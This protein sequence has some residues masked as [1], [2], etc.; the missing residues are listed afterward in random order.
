MNDL[1]RGMSLPRRELLIREMSSAQK[2]QLNFAL[3][4]PLVDAVVN[5]LRGRLLITAA[6]L[7]RGDPPEEGTRFEAMEIGRE[8]PLVE[9]KLPLNLRTGV[10]LPDVNLF[11]AGLT[12]LNVL[13]LVNTG[14][15]PWYYH[16]GQKGEPLVDIY[17]PRPISARSYHNL[18]QE[19]DLDTDETSTWVFPPWKTGEFDPRA[20][21][22]G[23]YYGKGG[24][25]FK[26]HPSKQETPWT[27]SVPRVQDPLSEINLRKKDF[28]TDQKDPKRGVRTA[29]RFD[30]RAAQ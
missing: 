9:A 26:V 8:T 16:F 2:E 13:Q 5:L 7:H 21:L 17:Y 30:V 6:P 14:P 4:V 12:Q 15:R 25:V 1:A 19:F 22:G 10:N 27:P 24:K 23:L 18:G 3:Q 28:I 11:G 20:L 29:F